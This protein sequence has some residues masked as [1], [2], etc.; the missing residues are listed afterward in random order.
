MGAQSVVCP[1]CG[2]VPAPADETSMWVRDGVDIRRLAK[3]QR[4]LLW[5]VLALIAG[6]FA[7]VLLASI[8]PTQGAFLIRGVLHIAYLLAM[9]LIL[10]GALQMLH[11]TGAGVLTIVIYAIGMLIPYINLLVLLLINGTAVG[12]LRRAG[13]HVGF[14]GVKDEEVLRILCSYLCRQC[15]YNL[16]GNVSG[17]CPEC[18]TPVPAALRSCAGSG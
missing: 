16:T 5:M 6:Q 13:L 9:I 3:R 1:H 12:K 10:M 11:A 2:R 8:L 18:G 14:M 17:R 7:P 4:R 15:G